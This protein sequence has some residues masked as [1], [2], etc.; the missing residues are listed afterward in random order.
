MV[1]LGFSGN[2]YT[3]R[4]DSVAIRLDRVICNEAWR[5]Q[6]CE[7]AVVHLP[8]YKSDHNPLW[9]RLDP[10]KDINAKRDRP[11]RF[12][13]PW[14]LHNDFS[15][16]VKLAWSEGAR[17][18]NALN[19]FYDKVKV[20]NRKTFGLRHVKLQNAAF[21]TKVGWGLVNQKDALWVRVL[22]SKYRCGDDILP[23]MKVSSNSSRL[24]RAV[25][26][27]WP[28]VNDGIEWRLGDDK[29]AKFWSDA[30][31]PNCGKL[32]EL[33]TSPVSQS[34][35]QEV[36]ADY[37]T[38]SGGWDWD[39]F[40]YRLPDQVCAKITAIQPPSS[41]FLSDQVAWKY[42]NDG[43]F[44]VKTAY[45][46][47]AGN[48]GA[49]SDVFS[50][51]VWRLRV[52]QR[53]RSC[54]WLC[55]HNKLLT[56]AERV[57][58]GMTGVASCSRCGGVYEDVIHAISDCPKA[59]HLWM[60]LV[61]SAHWPEFFST[62]LQG[63]LLTNVSKQLGRW[64]NEA[65]FGSGARSASD[66]F[67]TVTHR[68][69]SYNEDFSVVLNQKNRV[70]SRV[71]RVIKWDKPDLGW[72]KIDVDEIWARA[73][74]FMPSSGGCFS[75]LEMALHY[76]HRKVVIEMDSLVACE[77]IKTPLMD[78]HPCAALLRDINRRC[79]DVGEVIFQH[80]YKEGNR[81]ADALALLAQRSF[82]KLNLLTSPPGEIVSLLDIDGRGVGALRSY[83]G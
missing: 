63:W 43:R 17:W 23:E 42:T 76:R 60:R 4:R 38:P 28:H 51:K 5:H 56:N 61:R 72:I 48:Q 57:R 32:V 44:S 71:N 12:L 24:W 3:W 67:F 66:W 47:L 35:L 19:I 46:E 75:G 2:A 83:V 6:F 10:S 39:R 41:F 40:E 30:W 16:V 20:W 64:R 79:C 59:K 14:V 15:N 80:V 37:I 62:D 65:I 68:A 70:P 82:F 13:A 22:R 31:I 8:N 54:L 52:P 55:G 27:N 73:L 21:M 77:L 7:A 69:R 26:R 53:V 18:G 81:V 1:D 34:E 78:S 36:V 33:A 9:I 50:K 74:L 11:F 29:H 25:V 58:R 45:Q 49:H